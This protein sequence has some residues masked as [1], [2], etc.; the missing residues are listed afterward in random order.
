MNI[1]KI[2]TTIILSLISALTFACWANYEKVIRI[3]NGD[4]V[5]AEYR[6]EDVDYIQVEDKLVE[7]K[8]GYETLDNLQDAI[9]YMD[10]QL[11]M[12]YYSENTNVQPITSDYLFSEMNVYGKTDAGSGFL[13]NFAE[14]LTPSNWIYRSFNDGL[15]VGWL[16]D[17]M[18]DHIMAANTTI[19]MV[20]KD[21][22]LDNTSKNRYLG[23]AYFHRAWAYYNLSFWF[24]DLPL[25]SALPSN[26]KKSYYSTPIVEI[27]KFLCE[28]LN[29]AIEWMPSKDN[30][31]DNGVINKEACR[32]LYIKCLLAAGNYAEAERQATILI[33]QSGLALM[34]EPFGTEV[35][36]LVPDTWEIQ[37][38]VIWDLHRSENKMISENR[39]AI[40]AINNENDKFER[41]LSYP[42]MRVFG[43]NVISNSRIMTPDNKGIAQERELMVIGSSK[44]D[45]SNDWMHASG[46]GI[47]IIRPTDWTQHTLWVDPKTDK[48]DFEDLRHNN[49]VGNWLRMEDRTYCQ[50]KSSYHGKNLLLYA[51]EDI[52]NNRGQVIL[53]KG[54]ILCEDTIRGW[55]DIP[56]YKIYTFDRNAY[57][58]EGSNDFQGATAKG[59]GNIYIYRLAETYLLRAEARLYLGNISGATD[60]VNLIRRRANASWYYDKVNIGDIMDERARELYL[61]E[62]RKLEL[63]RVSICMAMAG[64]KDE[65]GNTYDIDRVYEYGDSYWYKRLTRYSFYNKGIIQVQYS[66]PINYKISTHNFFWPI[67]DYAMLHFRRIKQNYGYDGYD[68]NCK[69]WKTWQ[70]ADEDA[71]K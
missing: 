28:N 7:D 57:G 2:T 8:S 19:D 55:F 9:E 52:K 44:Y 4:K 41:Y 61:E 71:R 3:Y 62:Y 18:W 14:K 15:M 46:R 36:S 17:K 21:N 29:T 11:C 26:S 67:P 59:D 20:E 34:T 33:E 58:K 53:A 48:E 12:M 68:S 51:P 45:P 25:V 22:S 16:W 1:N 10:L 30:L 31:K 32:Q 27:M 70:E 6:A 42:W 24:G 43:P 5:I 50:P 38:N 69:M 65:W 13:D 39:E 40:L 54:T 60:D 64:I 47:G 49:R 23:S 66:L 56:L 37:R 35:K 63:T